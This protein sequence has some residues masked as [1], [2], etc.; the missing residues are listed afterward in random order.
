[1]TTYEHSLPPVP[2]V[3]ALRVLRTAA[4]SAGLGLAVR[5]AVALVWATPFGGRAL[6][7]MSGS[8]SPALDPGDVVV[9]T[10]ISPLDARLGDV[11]AFRDPGGTGRLLTHRVRDIRIDGTQVR[12]VTRGDANTRAERWSVPGSGQIGRA[13]YR[14]PLLGYLLTWTTGTLGKLLFTVLPIPILAFLVL[15]RIWRS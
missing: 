8:M 11:I 5:I 2:L 14:L 1:V 12:F 13:S 9:S 6:V 7:E 3:S 10:R 15:R 4:A